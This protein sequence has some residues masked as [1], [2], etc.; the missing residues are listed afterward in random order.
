VIQAGSHPS[1]NHH[2]IAGS[3][4]SL[5]GGEPCYLRPGSAEEIQEVAVHNAFDVGVAVAAFAEQRCHLLEVGDGREVSRALF[6]AEAA[7]E[8]RA[9]SAVVRVAG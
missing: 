2:G 8:I 9:D 3:R 6:F 7:V 4:P 1:L 5:V